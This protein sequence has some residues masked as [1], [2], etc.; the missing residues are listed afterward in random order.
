M[1]AQVQRC[2][3]IAGIYSMDPTI[4]AANRTADRP[5]VVY[6]PGCS[7]ARWAAK[8]DG[9]TAQNSMDRCGN[10]GESQRGKS[11]GTTGDRLL[12][13][14]AIYFQVQRLDRATSLKSCRLQPHPRP[15]SPR[16][17]MTL[18]F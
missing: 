12:R 13:K 5:V 1:A 10:R 9:S 6:D 3:E 2:D 15:L 14:T 18:S 11:P 16:H 8:H 7:W 4:W 17:F